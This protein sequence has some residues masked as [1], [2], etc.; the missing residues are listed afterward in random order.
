MEA[1]RALWVGPEDH[2]K[3]GKQEHLREKGPLPPQAQLQEAPLTLWGPGGTEEASVR[4]IQHSSFS[5]AI[6]SGSRAGEV[7]ASA[8]EEWLQASLGP[9]STQHLCSENKD[10]SWG[11]DFQ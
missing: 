11:C 8:P 4:P 2:S 9:W 10:T 7:L 1:S 3:G 6:C 5:R